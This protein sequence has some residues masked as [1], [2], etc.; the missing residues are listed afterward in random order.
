[1]NNSG[2]VL[3]T[4]SAT[5]MVGLLVAPLIFLNDYEQVIELIKKYGYIGYFLTNYLGG[6]I[7]TVPF[8]VQV[9]NPLAMV[10]IAALG[11]TIDEVFSWYAGS[12]T[13]DLK[14]EKK[15]HRKINEFIKRKGLIAT[16]TLAVLPLPN[17]LYAASGFA[18]GYYRIPLFNYFLINFMGKFIRSSIIVGFFYYYMN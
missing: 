9:L 12:K 10:L 15:Y 1:M 8:L 11:L 16:F 6:G 4:I 17:F 3:R 2:K 14:A 5:L 18:A 7:I 13:N